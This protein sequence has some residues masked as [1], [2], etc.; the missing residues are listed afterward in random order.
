MKR[1]GFLEEMPA[2]FAHGEV[3]ESD[4]VLTCAFLKTTRLYQFYWAQGT[5]LVLFSCDL[6]FLP[7]VS[8][9]SHSS[10]YDHTVK[11]MKAAEVLTSYQDAPWFL[12]GWKGLSY[13]AAG[14]LKIVPTFLS[15]FTQKILNTY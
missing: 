4:I 5:Q 10:R 7:G 15:S 14:I 11:E 13:I 9:S 8:P 12:S 3:R 6:I 1:Q 2:N